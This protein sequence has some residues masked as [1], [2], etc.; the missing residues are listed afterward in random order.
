MASRRSSSFGTAGRCRSY[1][2]ETQSTAALSRFRMLQTSASPRGNLDVP[3]MR[4]RSSLGM[5][6][7]VR[8]VSLRPDGRSLADPSAASYAYVCDCGKA[9]R[10]MVHHAA[11]ART[12]DADRWSVPT[13]NLK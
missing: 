8:E 9:D 5:T 4:P 12:R 1:R 6:N 7:T 10:L 2:V 3:T 11:G 13:E